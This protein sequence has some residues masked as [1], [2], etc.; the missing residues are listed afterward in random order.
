VSTAI[1][2]LSK[3]QIWGIAQI[4]ALLALVL[5]QKEQAVFQR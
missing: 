3:A 1:A 2:H 5:E 4:C